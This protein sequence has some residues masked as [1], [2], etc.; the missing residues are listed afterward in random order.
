MPS[1][2]Q[3]RTGVSRLVTIAAGLLEA[4]SRHPKTIRR[5]GGGVVLRYTSKVMSGRSV[6]LITLFLGRLR[7][8][9]L[10]T[11]TS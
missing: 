2:T 8:P 11:S 1:S 5:S 6:K 4:I 10:L 7:P 9:K 3:F